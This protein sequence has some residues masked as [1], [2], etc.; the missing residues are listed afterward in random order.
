MADERRDVE[1]RPACVHALEVAVER[2]PPELQRGRIG[3]DVSADQYPYAA[4]ETELAA[5]LPPWVT[6]DELP[7]VLDDPGAAARLALAVEDGEPGWDS[8]GRGIGWD[9]IVLGSHDPD[10]SLTGRSIADV[11]ESWGVEPFLAI[12]RL[13]VADRFTGMIGHA[14]HEDDVRAIVSRPDVFVATD[15]VA[16]SPAGPLGGVAVHPRYY[17]TYPRVLGRY[18]RD[19]RRLTLETAVAKM[20]SLPAERF[21]L[22]GRGRIEAG[23]A[24][25][26]V[27]FDPGTI[28]DTATYERPHAFA[29]GVELVV[30]NGE[31]GFEAGTDRA[32]RAG[33]ALRRG[34]R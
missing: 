25:D 23:A 5:A 15:G 27:V 2:V 20:T 12:A 31:I 21:G 16:I 22:A 28:A 18:A 29:D 32:A 7:A 8:A 1:R 33:R 34:E 3:A 4:W 9:R 24:A 17:G 13:L 6:P 10:P 26:L 11:A 19:E 14:M 30:V